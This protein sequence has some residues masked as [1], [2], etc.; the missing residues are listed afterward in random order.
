ME[1]L[2]T[3]ITDTI[4]AGYIELGK[5][6]NGNLAVQLNTADEPYA[7]LSTTVAGVTLGENEF[8]AK[9]YSE[10]TG[11]LEQFVENGL[12]EDTGRTTSGDTPIYKFNG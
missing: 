1:I 9:T 7:T 2:F 8:F 12:F 11:L 10:N 6:P 5:Y 3:H 4:Q